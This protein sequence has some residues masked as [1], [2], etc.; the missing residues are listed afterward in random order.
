[1]ETKW[2]NKGLIR[3]NQLLTE[4]FDGSTTTPGVNSQIYRA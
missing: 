1:M 2:V 3:L 4:V